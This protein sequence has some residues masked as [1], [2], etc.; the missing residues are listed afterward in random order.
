VTIPK[1]FTVL[2]PGNFKSHYSHWINPMKF[3]PERFK[4]EEYAKMH[5][6]A[7]TP[8]YSGKRRCIGFHIADLNIRL[9][10]GNMIKWFDLKMDQSRQIEFE[11]GGLTEVKEPIVKIRLR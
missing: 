11:V 7:W 3:S 2:V 6:L 1:G 8:F 9:L 4:S 5:E 10:I